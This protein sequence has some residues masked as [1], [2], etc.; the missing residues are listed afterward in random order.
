[1]APRRGSRRSRRGPRSGG[2]GD[3][4]DRRAAGGSQ[5]TACASEPAWRRRG[6]YLTGSDRNG[7]L[8]D[9]WVLT[10][11]GEVAE[12]VGGGTPKTGVPGNFDDEAGH[13]W[14]TPA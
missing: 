12:V 6:G 14:L 4:C 3:R 8:P 10:T 11:M 9:G 13:P 5:R 1:M 7:S 2:V